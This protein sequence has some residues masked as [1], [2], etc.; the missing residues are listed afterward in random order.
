MSSNI[1]DPLQN[2]SD[3]PSVTVKETSGDL[4]ETEKVL[5]TTTDTFFKEGNTDRGKIQ[6]G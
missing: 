6:C 4:D 2:K 1:S 3:N 5:V